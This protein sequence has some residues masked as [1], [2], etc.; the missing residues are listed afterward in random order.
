MFTVEEQLP[1]E[2]P[3]RNRIALIGLRGAGKS[4]LGA[5]LAK[6]L[7]VHFIELDHEIENDTGMPLAD[8]FSLYGQSGYRAI[9]RR[10]LERVMSRTRSRRVLHRWRCRLRA[11]DVRISPRPLLHRLDQSQARRTHGLASSRKEISARWPAM[12]APWTTCANY[13]APANRCIAKPTLSS[14]LQVQPW[15]TA[16]PN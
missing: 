11:G 15:K 9:E 8:I 7:N 4:T 3:S 16:S 12:I 10:T 5:K 1:V 13:S 6:A 14:T 2:T